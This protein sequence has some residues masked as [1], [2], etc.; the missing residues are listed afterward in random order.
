MLRDARCALRICIILGCCLAS[1]ISAVARTVDP[2]V[3]T[4]PSAA[5]TL[6]Y[7][8]G[9]LADTQWSYDKSTGMLSHFE[10]SLDPDSDLMQAPI[11]AVDCRAEA[12]EVN[13]S[14]GVSLYCLN[15]KDC[16]VSKTPDNH[17]YAAP[18]VDNKVYAFMP[19]DPDRADRYA[20]ALSH[21]VF[22][23]QQDYRQRHAANPNDPFAKP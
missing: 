22:L 14:S 9:A 11:L 8:N 2:C 6:A 13:A 18:K 15:Q 1:A 10:G 20:R 21:L 23:L 16:W 12:R 4:G 5:D 3:A 17:S 19:T 7:L